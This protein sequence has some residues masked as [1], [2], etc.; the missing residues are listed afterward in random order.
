[1]SGTEHL[2]D[3]ASIDRLFDQRGLGLDPAECHG[4]LCGLLCASAT[5]TGA[6][7][8]NQVLAGRLD[9]SGAEALPRQDG[10]EGQDHDHT[11]LLTLYKNTVG[12]FDD[13]EYGFSPFLPDDDE[14]LTRRV[15]ALSRWCQGFLLGLGLG[16]IQDLAKLPGDSHEVM[17]D[18]MEISRLG[19]G[20]AGDSNEDETA[21]AEIVE[22]VRMAALLVYEELR[23]LRA[24][25]PDGAPVH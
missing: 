9:L 16:G 17:R 10:A 25:R 21:F 11:L 22:Y 13:P 12:N 15:E 6:A 4:S 24:A 19:G 2:I 18:F 8:V 20:E 7:W 23:P 14:P 3:F 5:V 1:M